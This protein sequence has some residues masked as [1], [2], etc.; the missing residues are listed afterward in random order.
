MQNLSDRQGKNNSNPF[1]QE[2]KSQSNYRKRM[3]LKIKNKK[4]LTPSRGKNLIKLV[5]LVQGKEPQEKEHKPR[6]KIS[7][8]QL[9]DPI[10][11]LNLSNRGGGTRRSSFRVSDLG[12]V[13]S[14][15][16]KNELALP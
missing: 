8:D 14:G 15:N 16:H 12:K 4:S 6:P 10:K 7:L 3:S 11:S 1:W 2:L 5:P 9:P 13:M